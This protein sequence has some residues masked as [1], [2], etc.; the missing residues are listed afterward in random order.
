MNKK[1]KAP[2]FYGLFL[3]VIALIIWKFPRSPRLATL[4]WSRGCGAILNL[5]NRQHYGLVSAG[6][7][8]AA[9]RK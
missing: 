6:Q 3:A 5:D 1:F 2:F 4:A 9:S 7:A 8:D